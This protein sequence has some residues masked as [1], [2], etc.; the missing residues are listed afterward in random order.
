MQIFTCEQG[1]PEWFECRRGIPTASMF[2]TVMAQGRGGGESKTRRSYMMKLAGEII[3][4]EV[5][6]PYTNPDL[7]RGH[8]LEP[9]ARSLY[10][11][12]TGQPAEIVGFCRQDNVG[13]SPDALLGKN[14]ILEIKSALP[15]ILIDIILKDAFPPE[16]K[17]QCQGNLWITGREWIDIAVYWPKLPLFIK[18]AYRDEPYIKALALAV[19]CF[20]DELA[21]VVEKIRN[22]SGELEKAA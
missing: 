20:N 7:E 11:F 5:E 18:R 21:E 10:E 17:A 19:D 2:S 22:Y 8:A 14:G 9:E 15:H 6:A 3:T 16:H 12:V 4:G 13:C 1:S